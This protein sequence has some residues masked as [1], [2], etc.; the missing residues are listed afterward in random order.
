MSIK[1]WQP[2]AKLE[3]IRSRAKLLNDIRQFF[4]E[5]DVLEIE[6]PILVQHRCCDI[7]IQQFEVPS[8]PHKRFL[9]SSPEFA[10]KRLLAAGYGSIFQITK[11]F[12]QE[13]QGRY[14]NP[15]FTMLEWYRDG[16][17]DQQLIQEIGLLIDLVLPNLNIT[18]YSYLD[19]FLSTL[20]INPHKSSLPV[21]KKLSADYGL[22]DCDSLDKTFY[23]DFLFDQAVLPKLDNKNFFL[24][25]YPAEQAALAKTDYDNKGNFIAKRFELY[26]NGIEIANGYDELQDLQEHLQRAYKTASSPELDPFFKEALKSGLPQCSGVA[27]GIDRLLMVVLKA[28]HINQ[29]LSFPFDHA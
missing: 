6:T 20:N 22:N 26:L 5:R 3:T 21:L 28:D 10:M 7:H 29:V 1:P 19:A 11:A 16:F 2:Y 13:E 9:Q 24:Y 4:A 14:H 12:R 18:N 17:D 25:D 8:S 23:L 15:E 27:L